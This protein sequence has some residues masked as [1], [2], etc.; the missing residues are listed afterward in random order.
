MMPKQIKR[1][2]LSSVTLVAVAV[3]AVAAQRLWPAMTAT[4]AEYEAYADVPGIDAT[5]L[6]DFPLN[7]TTTVDVTILEA[8][9]DSA[10]A[11]LQKDF[12]IVPTPPEVLAILGVD[13]NITTFWRVSEIDY[14]LV[15]DGRESNYLLFVEQ[16]LR[17]KLSIFQIEDEKQNKLIHFNQLSKIK[18]KRKDK[19]KF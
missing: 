3:V 16:E 11:L 19:K 9:N 15:K 18:N 5:F 13:S 6:R 17:R 7:D 4:S 8:K 2:W 10:W 1:F 12:N 14:S